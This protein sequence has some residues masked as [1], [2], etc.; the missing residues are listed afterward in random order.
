MSSAFTVQALG[1]DG[2]RSDRC[3]YRGA[4][5]SPWAAARII[6]EEGNP[7]WKA[8]EVRQATDGMFEVQMELKEAATP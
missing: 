5:G 1:P 2:Q 6:A 4:I 8:G 7:G 3:R